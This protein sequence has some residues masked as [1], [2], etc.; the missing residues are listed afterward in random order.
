MKLRKQTPKNYVLNTN[1]VDDNNA[2]TLLEFSSKDGQE[3]D[4][5]VI[6]NI[7][8]QYMFLHDTLGWKEGL[9]AENIRSGTETTNKVAAEFTFLTEQMNWKKG[10]KLF[11]EQ[12]ESAIIKELKQIH[13][14]EGFEPKHWHE[15][16]KEERAWALKY[17]MYL[18]EKRDGRIKGRG[19]ADGRTQKM[20]MSK[21][22]TSS[23]TASLAG[24]IMT[25]V[26]DAFERQD[27]ATVDIPGA[28]LQ[29]KQPKEDKDVHVIL[30]G[31][32]AELL[33]KN[34]QKLTRNMSIIREDR[35]IYIA[36]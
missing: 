36:S 24:L 18:K 16:T 10:L 4:E 12:G 19:C 13:D 28:F 31:R 9:K 30:N 21:D 17:L 6:H 27:V 11:G 5:T 3:L 34:H 1:D 23:P 22:E 29:A 33:A 8:A 7:H 25:C 15:L 26:I 14:M 35:H 20:W 32:M 2:I